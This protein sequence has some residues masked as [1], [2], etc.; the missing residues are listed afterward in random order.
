MRKKYSPAF[1]AKVALAALREEQT[2]A[3]LSSQFEVHKA[4]IQR[5]KKDALECLP[6]IFSSQ[7]EKKVKKNDALIEELYKQIGQLK[8]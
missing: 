4:Q 6:H 2:I 3:Q 1:K 7:I 5:W 8:V